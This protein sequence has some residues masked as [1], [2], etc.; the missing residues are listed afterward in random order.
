LTT[1]P[2]RPPALLVLADGTEFVG[3]AI[4]AEGLASGEVVFN[5]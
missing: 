4:G 5:T 2:R 3:T 1:Q